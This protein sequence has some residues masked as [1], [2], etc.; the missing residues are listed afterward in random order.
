[1]HL[2]QQTV[3][4]SLSAVKVI[5]R[6]R[7][8]SITNT[9]NFGIG[10]WLAL[11]LQKMQLSREFSLPFYLTIFNFI[12]VLFS[13]AKQIF[14]NYCFAKHFCC[15]MNFRKT[16][17]CKTNSYSTQLLTKSLLTFCEN[18]SRDNNLVPLSWM[19]CAYWQDIVDRDC[20]LL[21]SDHIKPKNTTVA[22]LV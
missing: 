14:A 21:F 3:V 1:M 2:Y 10:G 18:S 4:T 15:E 12:F 8:M 13:I 22:L 9:W 19:P 17:F 5:Y 11:V 20:C 6:R 16:I 7:N